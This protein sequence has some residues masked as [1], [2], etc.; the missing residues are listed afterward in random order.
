MMAAISVSMFESAPGKLSIAQNL[1]K[2][3]LEILTGLGARGQVTALVRG[4][5]PNSLGIVSEFEDA[6]AYGAG[7]DRIFADEGF[8]QF[9]NRAQESEALIP[10]R[11]VDYAEIPG[12]EVPFAAVESAGVIL[13][14][15]FKVRNGKQEQS[16]VRIARAKELTEKHGGKVRALQ[17]IASDPFGITAT[18]IYYENFTEYGKAGM[19]LNNDP[20]WQAFGAEIRGEEASSDFLRTSL[21]RIL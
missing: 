12:M 19:A 21:L 8:Q 20:D 2:E 7:L 18:A 5:V 10:V 15:V 17:A 4:G 1:L 11:S 13:A 14:T 6:E 3:G 9:I 16:L